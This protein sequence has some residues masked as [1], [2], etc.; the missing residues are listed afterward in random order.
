[1]LRP[2]WL[3]SLHDV[4]VNNMDLKITIH[5]TESDKEL[6]YEIDAIIESSNGTKTIAE[7]IAAWS[8]DEA[9]EELVRQA[10]SN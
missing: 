5:C 9:M 4:L 1:M 2:Q 8:F 7:T 6:G 10:L 3:D